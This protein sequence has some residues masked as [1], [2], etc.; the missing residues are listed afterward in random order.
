MIHVADALGQPMEHIEGRL[1]QLYVLLPDM[2]GKL[3][4]MKAGLVL[5]YVQDVE[6]RAWVGCTSLHH[7]TTQGIATKLVALKQLLPSTNLS[8][9]AARAPHLLL[10][11]SV[12]DVAKQLDVLREALPGAD[13][14]DLI[15][16]EPLLLRAN[17]G[18]VL[19]TVDRLMPGADPVKV[20]QA[21]PTLV[22]PMNHLKCPRQ[23]CNL[24]R[25]HFAHI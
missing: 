20:L 21:N 25:N 10:Q 7:P 23:S 9:L 19:D 16:R 18:E 15:N 3:E 6:V 24:L 12:D 4:R 11:L 14:E 2:V 13:V 8:Q 5:Q 22:M 1:R 17:I